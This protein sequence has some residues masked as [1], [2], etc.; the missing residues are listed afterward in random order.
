LLA[1]SVGCL[2]LYVS[3]AEHTRS[4][5]LQSMHFFSY[6]VDYFFAAAAAL[7]RILN[8]IIIKGTAAISLFCYVYLPF[9][10]AAAA[11][12]KSI[13]LRCCLQK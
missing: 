6:Q 11:I 12:G 10:A 5:S 3:I 8:L 1:A 4:G 7:S 2:L 13:Q 9:C